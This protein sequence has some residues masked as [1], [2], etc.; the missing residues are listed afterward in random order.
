MIKVRS[1]F[2]S[3]PDDVRYST[4]WTGLSP[5]ALRVGIGFLIVF[6]ACQLAAHARAETLTLQRVIDEA[7]AEDPGLRALAGAGAAES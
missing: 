2:S 4:A 5:A 3:H 7:L 1:T 6:S